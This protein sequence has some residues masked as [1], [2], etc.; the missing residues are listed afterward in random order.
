MCY[1]TD[2]PLTF[3]PIHSV[4]SMYIVKTSWC[5]LFND[6]KFFVSMKNFKI[7]LSIRRKVF[8]YSHVN[9]ATMNL[10]SFC[11]DPITITSFD[12]IFHQG[13]YVTVTR[14]S[15]SLDLSVWTCYFWFS[16]LT[17]MLTYFMFCFINYLNLVLCFIILS[18]VLK[19]R[20]WR[21][22]RIRC[23]C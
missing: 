18:F 6:Y 7:S 4:F 14:R 21:K 8:S 20:W 23:S 2:N 16:S 15:L 22:T 11:G 5:K 12:V 10:K 3:T 17:L 19:S 1:L 9:I 13:T